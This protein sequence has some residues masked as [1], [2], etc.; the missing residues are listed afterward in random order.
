MELVGLRERKKSQTRQ[1]IA[2]AATD[3][4]R[5][6]GYDAVTVDDVANAAQVSKKTIFNYFSTK[7]D[8]VFNKAEEREHELLAAVRDRVE[9]ESLVDAFRRVSLNRLAGLEQHRA[10]HRPGGFFDLVESSPVLQRRA[11][12]V[13]ARLV[14]VVAEALRERTRAHA[15]DPLPGAMAE[16]LLGAQRALAR[17]LRAQLVGGE[18][19]SVIARRHRR[20]INRVFDRLRDGLGACP[21]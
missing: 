9:G 11:A 19:I 10:G 8:L 4:F 14:R 16:V 6:Y 21:D 7:E 5:R 3:L 12:E 2:D 13:Q 1:A 17:G 20:Q 15:D 18:D